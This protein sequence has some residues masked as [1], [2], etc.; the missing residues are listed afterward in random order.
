MLNNGEI[1]AKLMQEARDK[2]KPFVE[3]VVEFDIRL[4]SKTI[5]GQMAVLD[6]EYRMWD[7]ESSLN[8]FSGRHTQYWENGKIIKEEYESLSTES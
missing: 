7:S 6:F 3:A 2:Q 1:F 4:F 5:V 8:H